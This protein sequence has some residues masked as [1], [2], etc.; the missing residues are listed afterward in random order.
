MNKN[1]IKIAVIDSGYKPDH[2]LLIKDKKDFTESG[3][4]IDKINH[5]SD[6]VDCIIN[7]NPSVQIY[8]AKIFDRNNTRIKNLLEALKWIIDL[9]V[10]IVNMSFGTD[11][12]HIEA[13]NLFNSLHR[14][15]IHLV[16]SSPS[17]GATVYPASFDNVIS[18]TGDARCN[19]NEFSIQP[20]TQADYGSSPRNDSVKSAGSSIATANFTG[21][22]A[23]LFESSGQIPLPGDLEFFL[24]KH[25]KIHNPQAYP[26]N[27]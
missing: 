21:I 19:V 11:K 16:A 13:A 17:I 1:P 27:N 18:V 14:K 15:N 5:G 7:T 4:C 10:D 22:I 12:F 3:S 24:N 26:R 2:E 8:C 23:N 6:V 20:S 25:T 9:E